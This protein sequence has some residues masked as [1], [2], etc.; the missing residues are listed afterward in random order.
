M[1]RQ[2]LALPDHLE[3]ANAPKLQQFFFLT[4]ELTAIAPRQEGDPDDAVRTMVI[5]EN[6]NSDV[7]PQVYV[8]QKRYVEIQPE[9]GVEWVRCVVLSVWPFY[10]ER[11]EITDNKRTLLAID[12]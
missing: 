12:S 7:P 3:A 5:R 4:L 6:V 10:G 8:A 11:E 1:S 9:A 2:K